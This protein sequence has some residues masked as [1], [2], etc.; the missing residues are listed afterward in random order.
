MATVCKFVADQV[1]DSA[2]TK[3]THSQVLLCLGEYFQPF[4]QNTLK[5]L[6]LLLTIFRYLL[7]HKGVV[8]D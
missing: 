2:R 5:R 6:I 3:N 1:A 4:T 7:K 8:L